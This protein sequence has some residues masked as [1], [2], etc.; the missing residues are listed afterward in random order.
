MKRI[1][2]LISSFGSSCP[3]T[4]LFKKAI[5][6][7]RGEPVIDKA[8]LSDRERD[9]LFRIKLGQSIVLVGLFCPI[10]WISFFSGA[11]GEVLYYNAF[12]S[13]LVILFGLGFILKYRI[14]LDKERSKNNV[15]NV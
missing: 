3:Y 14:H 15:K 6:L 2:N 11:R 5:R 8:R 13:G 1:V 12:H 9:L 7:L 4:M 10:F